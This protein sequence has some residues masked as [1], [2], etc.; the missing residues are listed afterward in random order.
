MRYV[1]LKMKLL[2]LTLLL[3][4]LL[5]NHILSV[6]TLILVGSVEIFLLQGKRQ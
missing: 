1:D 6:I 3:V 2:A 5:N 4:A